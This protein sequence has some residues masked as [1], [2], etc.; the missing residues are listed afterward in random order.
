MKSESE[1]EERSERKRARN[2][3]ESERGVRKRKSPHISFFLLFYRTQRVIVKRKKIPRKILKDRKRTR[4][5]KSWR[6]QVEIQTPSQLVI[7]T[8]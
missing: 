6:N 5:R 7:M 8:S 2:V 1:R 4:K 3:R